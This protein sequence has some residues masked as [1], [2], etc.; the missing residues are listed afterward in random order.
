MLDGDW[1]RGGWVGPAPE[2]TMPPADALPREDEAVA[3]PVAPADAE[4]AEAPD[5]PSDSDPTVE[6]F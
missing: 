2:A 6:D 4:S 3:A 5:V 1:A